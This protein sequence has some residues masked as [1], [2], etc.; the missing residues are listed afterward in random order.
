LG[1]ES[2]LPDILEWMN[3]GQSRLNELLDYAQGYFGRLN[4]QE[5][6]KQ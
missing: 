6:D 3:Q 2:Q 1:I 4:K 5:G